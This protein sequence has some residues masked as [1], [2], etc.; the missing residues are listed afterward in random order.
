MKWVDTLRITLLLSLSLLFIYMLARR[1]KQKVMANELPV[2]SHAELLSLQVLYH[3]ARLRMEVFLP[4]SEVL[5]PSVLD[6]EHVLVHKWE[7]TDHATGEHV[8]ELSLID[9]SNGDYF[10]ELATSSQRTVRKFSLK[11]A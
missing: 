8:V 7:E 10:L 4:S 3:P 6:A 11:H 9:L 2:A 5:R 1:F